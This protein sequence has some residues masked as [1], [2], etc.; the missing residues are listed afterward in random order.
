MLQNGVHSPIEQK[1][2]NLGL[3]LCCAG[4]EDSLFGDRLDKAIINSHPASRRW[5][6]DVTCVMTTL[7]CST[8]MIDNYRERKELQILSV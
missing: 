6:I 2:S 5:V 3:R 7:G 1:V 8:M 4:I